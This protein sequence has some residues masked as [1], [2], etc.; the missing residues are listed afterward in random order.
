MENGWILN[1]DQDM[2]NYEENGNGIVHKSV[3]TQT[4]NG[5]I[6]YQLMKPYI[7]NNI[8]NA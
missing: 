3:F 2:V 6:F 5:A 8:A 1:I 7:I 4:T